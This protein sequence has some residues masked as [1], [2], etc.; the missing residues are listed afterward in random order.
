MLLIA[1]GTKAEGGIRQDWPMSHWS[2]SKRAKPTRT[3]PEDDRQTDSAMLSGSTSTLD[4]LT[5][6][7]RV[8]NVNRSDG[9]PPS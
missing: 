3:D 5:S 6:I 4:A 9:C 8:E 1:N 7:V 2:Q